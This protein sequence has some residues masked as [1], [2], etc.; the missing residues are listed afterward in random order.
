MTESRSLLIAQVCPRPISEDHPAARHARLLARGLAER[1]HRVVIVAPSRDRAAVRTSR[2]AITT[3]PAQLI[4]EP[5]GEPTQVAI[6]EVSV[7]VRAGRREGVLP[8]DVTRALE[9]LFDAVPFDICHLHD[10]LPPSVGAAAL[11]ASGALNVATFHG[12]PQR[13]LSAPITRRMREQ[14]FGRLD[15]R[16]ATSLVVAHE[17]ESLL[18]GSVTPIAPGAVGVDAAPREPLAG[19]ALRIAYLGE[20]E[21]GAL[22]TVL[23]ALRLLPDDLDWEARLITA[24][25]PSTSAPLP[26][27][28]AGQ[29]RFAPP[30]TEEDERE[31]LAWADVVVFR[32]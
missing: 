15:A 10:P 12:S 23:R 4:P 29:V 6:G 27:E 17:V 14:R 9:E 3:D 16:L 18:G 21:R 22:R 7:S 24:R 20:E 25:G 5:G 11:K 32:L 26:P 1:G 28:L 19:R 31:L 2:A 8:V 30:G 13:A